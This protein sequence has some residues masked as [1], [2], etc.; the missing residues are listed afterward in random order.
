M[1]PSAAS[2]VSDLA[3][4]RSDL[5]VCIIRP[6]FAF[7][8]FLAFL[9]SPLSFNHSSATPPLFAIYHVIRFCRIIGISAASASLSHYRNGTAPIPHSLAYHGSIRSTFATAFASLPP[10][11]WH[12]I[13]LDHIP[14]SAGY[15]G[16]GTDSALLSALAFFSLFAALR[17]NAGLL[18]LST[19]FRPHRFARIPGV[20]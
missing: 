1:P 10:V 13:N 12:S 20:G 8:S 5:H 4:F 19:P 3:G 18:R 17:Y 11:R 15:P 9:P 14:I 16:S 6:F 7:V 2:S